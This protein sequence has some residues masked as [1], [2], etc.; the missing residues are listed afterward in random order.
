MAQIGWGISSQTPSTS[1]LV[2]FID[3]IQYCLDIINTGWARYAW[4][5]LP[6]VVVLY[7]RIP[8]VIIITL[9]G[10]RVFSV[11]VLRGSRVFSIEVLRGSC[12][13]LL[14]FKELVVCFL[15]QF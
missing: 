6:F 13:F 4:P 5:S 2:T 1:L 9:H 7:T 12:V 3:I 10:S 15:L 14:K 8:Y 11:T